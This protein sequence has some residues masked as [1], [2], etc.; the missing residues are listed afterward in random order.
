[1]PGSLESPDAPTS[2]ERL[3]AITQRLLTW[4]ANHLPD[5]RW[6]HASDP[7]AIWMAVVML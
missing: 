4:T 1:M 6:R 2:P 5:F 3:H 7:Y